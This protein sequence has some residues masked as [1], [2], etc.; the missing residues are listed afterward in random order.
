[1]PGSGKKKKYSA[2]SIKSSLGLIRTSVALWRCPFRYIPYI[3]QVS[4]H[5]NGDRKSFINSQRDTLDTAAETKD[6]IHVSAREEGCP[7]SISWFG[8]ITFRTDAS[9]ALAFRARKRN[10]VCSA[11]LKL[12]QVV[13]LRLIPIARQ[14]RLAFV[15]PGLNLISPA[16]ISIMELL[17]T[18]QV[19]RAAKVS[20]ERP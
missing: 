14:L 8:K 18:S 5:F 10:S 3:D 7:S 20:S 13:L 1:M 17:S 2:Q 16:Q 4:F 19:H 11:G 15:F 6:L 12:K 9:Q